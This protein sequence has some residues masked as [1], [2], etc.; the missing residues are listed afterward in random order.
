MSK[1]HYSTFDEAAEA[2]NTKLRTKY[3]SGPEIFIYKSPKGFGFSTKKPDRKLGQTKVC[4]YSERPNYFRDALKAIIGKYPPM[5]VPPY[6]T[7]A[8]GDEVI[9]LQDW[10]ADNARP[11]WATGLSMIE[12]AEL[13]VDQAIEN[14][15]I[16]EV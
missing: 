10:C 3:G 8:M 7:S 5:M 6:S 16:R 1:E 14:A 9:E 13:I 11:Q 12:A 4:V 15:N 2:A